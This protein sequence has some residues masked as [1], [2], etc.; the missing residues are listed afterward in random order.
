MPNGYV[1]AGLVA[2]QRPST[3]RCGLPVRRLRRVPAP[4]RISLVTPARS[5]RTAFLPFERAGQSA[6]LRPYACKHLVVGGTWG[7]RRPTWSHGA[8]K[9]CLHDFRTSVLTSTQPSRRG[10]VSQI[11]SFPSQTTNLAGGRAALPRRQLA[12]GVVSKHWQGA[13]C[14]RW[15]GMPV[16]N[17][18]R[19]VQ[20]PRVGALR[21]TL[22]PVTQNVGRW[23]GRPSRT[24]REH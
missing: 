10:R 2:D 22:S 17:E 3:P 19:L 12:L 24:K 5:T 18:R 20:A 8:S 9:P 15:T 4:Q 1:D 13:V 23:V 14:E 21:R 7:C 6:E 16:S 11:S